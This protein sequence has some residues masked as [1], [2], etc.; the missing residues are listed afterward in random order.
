MYKHIHKQ[1]LTVAFQGLSS[2]RADL[3]RIKDDLLAVNATHQA[4]AMDQHIEQTEGA[5]RDLGAALALIPGD[6]LEIIEGAA[7]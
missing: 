6:T 5:M 4:A 3:Q 1:T 2:L 7:A